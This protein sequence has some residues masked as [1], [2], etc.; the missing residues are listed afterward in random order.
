MKSIKEVKTSYDRDYKD[1]KFGGPSLTH[2]WIL[3][4]L[5][6]KPEK[7]LL[8]I[9]CGQ[10]LL[11]HEAQKKGLKTYG[12][13]ISSE[14]V[15]LARVNSPESD[16]VCGDAAKLPWENAKFDYITNIGSLEHFRD[17]EGCLSQMKRTLKP[18]GEAV[19]MLPNLYYYRHIMDKLFRGKN[20]TSYQAVERFAKRTVWQDLLEKNG[21]KVERVHKYNKFNRNRFMIWLRTITVPL[22]FSHHFVFI[23]KKNK[24]I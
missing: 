2:R 22:D 18:E 5:K 3:D 8:D 6:V 23:C 11:L 14:A 7:K 15:K 20:P 21:F 13:D 12:I 19:V 1:G 9:G 24:T 17:P 16:L 4:L 10:G